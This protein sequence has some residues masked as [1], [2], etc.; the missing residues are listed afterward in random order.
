MDMSV[1]AILFD[2]DGTLLDTIQDLSDALNTA[3]AANGYPPHSADEYRLMIGEGIHHLAKQA[4][5]PSER[6]DVQC[7]EEFIARIRKE[8]GRRWNVKTTPYEG[9]PELLDELTTRGMELSVLSNKP[10][11]F[12]C[13]SVK[14]FLSRWRFA[15]VVGQRSD[16]PMK[17]NPFAALEI[18]RQLGIAPERFL[19][20]GDSGVDMQ[21]A[22]AAGMK[23]I[24]VL[25]GFRGK[26]ELLSSGAQ[27]LIEHPLDLIK[28]LP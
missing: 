10:H 16:V 26:D 27:H 24:G 6:D 13:L 3:L 1:K 17:P 21:T 22:C 8:Y 9:V 20:V 19:Y 4:L 2:L 15:Q 18:A 23:S 11:A 7:I 25:W 28:H 12:T 14:H 5:P